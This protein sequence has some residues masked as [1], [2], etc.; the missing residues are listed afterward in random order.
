MDIKVYTIEQLIE[1][2]KLGKDKTFYNSAIW[3]SKREEILGRDNYECQKHK[4]RG[5]YAKAQTVHH[6]KHLKDYP[7]LAIDD[8]NLMSL[9]NACHNEEHPEKTLNFNQRKVRVISKEKW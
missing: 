5:K 9:C 7:E 6:K 3:L 4:S 8:D 1:L 2:I